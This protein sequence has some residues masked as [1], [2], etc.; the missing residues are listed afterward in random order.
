MMRVKRPPVSPPDQS[1]P[2]PSDQ[3]RP[4]RPSPLLADAVTAWMVLWTK[5]RQEKAVARYL[6]AAGVEHYLPLVSR[7]TVSPA[8]RKSS[9]RIPLF[10]GYVFATGTRQDGYDAIA[11]K[12]V[13]QVIDVPDQ[14]QFL[15]EIAQIRRAVDEDGVI[16]LY[17][18]A[19]VGR[20]VRVTRGPFE[21]IEGVIT[22]RAGRNRL[23]LGIGILGQGA[24]LAI[25]LDLVEPID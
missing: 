24:E 7:V 12:R 11:T 16:D 18:F 21:G 17:P 23:V 14:E 5:P 3:D 15:R 20:K 13:S 6:E 19:V 8:G 4:S 25:D 2:R 22:E 1:M 9:S 10:P